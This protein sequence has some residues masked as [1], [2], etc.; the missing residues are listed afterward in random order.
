MTAA[1]DQTPDDS[2]GKGQTAAEALRGRLLAVLDEWELEQRRP[3]DGGVAAPYPEPPKGDELTLADAGRIRRAEKVVQEALPRL[4]VEA[5]AKRMS[6]AEIARA[7]TIS[8]AYIYRML[9]KHALFA[10]RVDVRD[11][12]EWSRVKAGREIF[13]LNA[14]EVCER[15][16]AEHTITAD[17]HLRVTVW[18]VRDQSDEPFYV[19]EHKPS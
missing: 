4:I 11:G 2:L 14:A 5:D 8:E 7:L 17:R 16:V 10:Y 6:P 18:R 1:D 19:H 3:L 12:G 15:L 13:S 9:R